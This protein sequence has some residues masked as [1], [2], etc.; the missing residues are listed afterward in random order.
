MSSDIKT[1]AGPSAPAIKPKAVEQIELQVIEQTQSPADPSTPRNPERYSVYNRREKWFLVCLASLSALLSPL[2]ANIYFPALPL[3]A[4]EF[5]KS[6]E[7]INLTV[8]GYMVFQGIAPAFWAPIADRYGRR[9]VFIMCL[10][11]LCLSCIGLALT[12][13]N[14]YWL[15]L[16]LRCF[17]AAGSASTVAISAGLIVDIAEPAERGGFLGLYIIGPTAGPTFGPV[18]GGAL[19]GNLGWRSIFWFM[20]IFSGCVLIVIILVLPETLR[21]LVGDGSIPAP[22]FLRPIIRFGDHATGDNSRRPPRKEWA[23][24][25]RLFVNPDIV[26]VLVP[27]AIVSAVFYGVSTTISILFQKTYPFLSETD[28]GLCYVAIGGGCIPGSYVTG[29]LLDKAYKAAERDYEAK[30]AQ[31]APDQSQGN[32]TEKSPFEQKMDVDF[33][34]ERARLQMMPLNLA[35]FVACTIGYGWCLEAGV[36]LSVPLILSFFIGWT[37]I[38]VINMS[39]TLIMDLFPTQGSSI[40][41]S[42]N[43]IRCTTGAVLVAVEQLVIDA[44]NPGWTFVIFGG[45]CVVTYPMILYEM[46]RG[47]QFR[48]RRMKRLAEKA[49]REAEAQAVKDARNP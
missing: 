6:L 13:T 10:S 17:Q 7:L 47:P 44:V 32:Q 46:I 12:P 38:A 33:P 22:R 21:S 28:I 25:A 41:A 48:E 23:N 42:N 27:T 14:A 24:P 16:L 18:I 49:K 39:Q 35:V 29:K 19:S 34:L 40:T 8:T 36:H 31:N 2:T 1:D 43:L 5:H 37:S 20:C 4:S 30:K 11:T 3:L 26:L 45:L 15:L 9:L